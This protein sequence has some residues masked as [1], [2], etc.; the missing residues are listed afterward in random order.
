MAA[1]RASPPPP[2]PGDFT[3]RPLSELAP[4]AH[5]VLLV[6]YESGPKV[7]VYKDPN[8][9]DLELRVTVQQ[10]RAMAGTHRIT[11]RPYFSGGTM[12][13]LRD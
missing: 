4:T 8:F 9:G 2:S 13:Q 7:V 1:A 5:A 6:R 3:L 12:N 10:F 11:I